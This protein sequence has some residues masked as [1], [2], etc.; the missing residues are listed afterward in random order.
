MNRREFLQCAA[1][2][3]AGT[4]AMP[5]SWAMNHKQ[6]AFLAGQANYI[7]RKP[8]TFFSPSQRALVTTIAEHVIPKTDTPGASDAG[9]PRF[10]EL[11]ASDWFNAAEL[12]VFMD[13]LTDLQSRADD[14]FNQLS[15]NAQLALLEELE[16]E[17][18]DASWYELGNVLRVWDDTAPFICQ[19]KELTALGFFLSEVG[20]KQVLRTNPMGE[21]DGDIP[22][23]A[24]DPAYAAELPIR[25]LTES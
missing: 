8:L 24:D 18:A 3:A 2:L 19:F 5:A 12:Q 11:M 13:G 4:T 7:D 15:R 14:G 23:A 20:A 25:M 6:Q 16:E 1:M 9:V 17:S 22:L 10:I 21:F